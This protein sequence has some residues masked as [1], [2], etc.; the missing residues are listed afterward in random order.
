[1][2]INSSVPGRFVGE[3]GQH[4]TVRFESGDETVARPYSPTNLPGTDELMLTI[5]RY[6]DGLASS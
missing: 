1:M 6:D 3:Y 5:R 2:S 4:T